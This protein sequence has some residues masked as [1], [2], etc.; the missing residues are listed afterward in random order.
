MNLHVSI[1][2]LYQQNKP[3]LSL[4][5]GFS[6]FSASLER[7]SLDTNIIH[8]SCCQR[9]NDNSIVVNF[10][11]LKKSNRSDKVLRL[12]AKTNANVSGKDKQLTVYVC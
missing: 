1:P 4:L 8:L 7:N 9:R 10:L 12:L 5:S 3:L 11:R 6:V 2:P